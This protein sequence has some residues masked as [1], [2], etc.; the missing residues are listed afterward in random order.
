[1]DSPRFF[2]GIRVSQ[3]LDFCVV[4][5]KPFF[6]IFVIYL[7]VIVFSSLLSLT[8]SDYHFAILKMFL[9]NYSDISNYYLTGEEW[10]VNRQL[11]DVWNPRALVGMWHKPLHLRWA[12]RDEP[13]VVLL[14]L[15]SEVKDLNHLAIQVLQ[16]LGGYN[17][18]DKT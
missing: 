12:L 16:L 1:M 5:C 9:L 14:E 15:R 11:N 4:Y 8:G 17:G 18:Y 10:L 13:T 3:S 7:S 6:C 2:C